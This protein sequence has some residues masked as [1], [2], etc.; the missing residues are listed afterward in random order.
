[1][2]PIS[3]QSPTIPVPAQSTATQSSGSSSALSSDFETFL[4]M[5][6][7]QAQYQDPLEPIDASDYSAQLAQFSMVEQQVLSNDLL[8]SLTAALGTSNMA[9]LAGWVGMEARADSAARFTGAPVTLVPAAD[10]SADQARLIVR[11]TSGEIVQSRQIAVTDRLVEW[12]GT[13]T[14]GEGQLAPG[15]YRFEVQSLSEGQ[16]LSTRPVEVY[17]RI[18]EAQNVNGVVQL[19]MAG[20]DV[21][22]STNIGALREAR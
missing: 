4:R 11:D 17:D 3:S 9:S 13:G 1:M 18:V 2:D 16:I 12:D 10:T 22:A 14:A 19:V 21:V 6:T 20:G 15:V 7:A 8:A 5:L